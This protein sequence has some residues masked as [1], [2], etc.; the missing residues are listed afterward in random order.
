LESTIQEISYS[1]SLSIITRVEAS[2]VLLGKELDVVGSNID[3]WETGW[4]EYIDS[5]KW[6]VNNNVL[7]WEMIL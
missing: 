1:D 4:T 5:E 7:G 6:R 3:T 2:C